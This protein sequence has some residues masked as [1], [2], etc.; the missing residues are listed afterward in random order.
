M[1]HVVTFEVPLR[2]VNG[3][4][5]R[6]HHFAAA[7]RVKRQRQDFVMF[8]RSMGF[9]PF[10]KFYTPKPPRTYAIARWEPPYTLPLVVTIT[11]L[12]PRRLDDDGAT[13]S[14]KHVRDQLAELLGVND[15]DSRVRW[16]V[17][18]ETRRQPGVRVCLEEP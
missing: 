6:E 1:R 17:L 5:A 2:L 3:T 13:A 9:M 15:N 11:R 16:I 10:V 8:A 12:G 4:N 7:R 14:A 18:Q